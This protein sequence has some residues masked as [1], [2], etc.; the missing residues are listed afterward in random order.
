MITTS[1]CQFWLTYILAFIIVHILF[2]SNILIC[3]MDI[4]FDCWKQ[5]NS[6]ISTAFNIT[7]TEL[8]LTFVECIIL[9]FP[10]HIYPLCKGRFYAKQLS[11]IQNDFNFIDLLYPD[12]CINMFIIDFNKIPIY[13]QYRSRKIIMLICIIPYIITLCGFLAYSFGINWLSFHYIH[14]A[15]SPDAVI[16]TLN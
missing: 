1:K 10:I 9:I 14:T 13:R 6:R 11:V 7:K 3:F 16:S 12:H 2:V 5:L 15:L 8:T 4:S